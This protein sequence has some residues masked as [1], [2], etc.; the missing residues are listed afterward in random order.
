[1]EKYKLRLSLD[2]IHMLKMLYMCKSHISFANALPFSHT[3]FPER[4]LYKIMRAFKV[5]AFCFCFPSLDNWLPNKQ[6]LAVKLL[7]F[8]YR[9]T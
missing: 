5:F 6:V 3:S 9:V 2:D 8:P 4:K 7:G 1:M